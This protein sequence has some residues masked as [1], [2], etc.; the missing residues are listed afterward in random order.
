MILLCEADAGARQVLKETFPGVRIAEDIVS[1]ES[2]PPDTELVAAGFPCIDVSRAGLRRGLHGPSTGM[3]RHVFRLLKKAIEVGRGVQNVLL[4]N[5]EAILDRHGQDPPL[6]RYIGRQLIGLGYNWAY[7]CISSAGFG[8]PNRRRRVFVVACRNGDPRDILLAQGPNPCTGGCKNTLGSTMCCYHCHMASM[9]EMKSCDTISFALDMGN[10]VSQPPGDVVPTFTTSND[11]IYLFL[12][13]GDHGMLRVEDAERLQGL[14]EGYTS[15][16]WPIQQPGLGGHR[17]PRAKDIDADKAL[18]KRWDLLGNA[19]T[20]PVAEW[21]GERFHN[22]F[23]F[24]FHHALNNKRMDDLLEDLE[25]GEEDGGRASY[26]SKDSLERYDDLT[27]PVFFSYIM[28]GSDT[29]NK[30]LKALED[31][32]SMEELDEVTVFSLKVSNEVLEET[33]GGDYSEEDRL[34]MFQYKVLKKSERGVLPSA[35]RVASKWDKESWPKAGWYIRNIGSFAVEYMSDSPVVTRF[36]PLGDFITKVGRKATQAELNSYLNRLQERG[37][38]AEN[39]KDIIRR[40]SG[41]Q[42]PGTTEITR[43]PDLLQDEDLVGDLVWAHD[44]ISNVWWP[45]EVWNPLQLPAGKHLDDLP[46][47]ALTDKQRAASLPGKD[48]AKPMEESGADLRVFVCYLPLGSKVGAWH[49]PEAVLPFDAVLSTKEKEAHNAMKRKDFRYSEDLR[50]AI[51]DAKD[52]L[53]LK[54]AEQGDRVE[55]MRRTRAA[56]AAASVNLKVRC[57]SCKTCMNLILGQR[58]YECLNQR[59]RASALSGHSGAQLAVCKEMAV[60]ARVKV[61]WDGDQTFYEGIIAHYDPVATEHTI[62]YLDGEVG[63]HKLW[64]HDERII[65]L[66][67]V[68]EWK[69]D[70]SIARKAL[71]AAQQRVLTAQQQQQR[72]QSTPPLPMELTEYEKGRAARIKQNRVTMEKMVGEVSKTLRLTLAGTFGSSLGLKSSSTM[73]RKQ[74][75]KGADTPPKEESPEQ[76]LTPDP[77]FPVRMDSTTVILT[78]SGRS[79]PISEGEMPEICIYC[80]KPFIEGHG[81]TDCTDCRKKGRAVIVRS[82]VHCIEAKEGRRKR[83]CVAWTCPSCL[84]EGIE[85]ISETITETQSTIDMSGKGKRKIEQR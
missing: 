77:V 7:R 74:H 9:N 13:N 53:A 27:E 31:G 45:G 41:E 44:D 34:Q 26:P 78:A 59:M 33:E 28:D 79:S 62:C 70:V 84:I 18:A 83:G 50:Q 82:H 20:V 21:L 10:A 25:P 69:R 4:E 58:R 42:L 38:D 19:V 22:P 76:I 43:Y 49:P 48:G 64:Q 57:G 11:K 23:T 54:N 66:S 6:M 68:N 2:L 75:S 47:E 72:G 15:P 16:C 36:I 30:T 80:E 67:P 65:L 32:Q 52:S 56:S 73:K 63:M 1:L 39:I 17:L 8:L 12:R 29:N 85:D 14:P 37:W 61:W 5:V 40:R 24:K 3:I 71:H 51:E 60:G 55:R 35:R 46:T 81:V